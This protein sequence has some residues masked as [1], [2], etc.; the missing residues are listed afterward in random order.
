K[1]EASKTYLEQ[2]KLLVTLAS[3]FLFAPAGLITILK[4]R[5]GAGITSASMQPFI[6]AE[7]LF[8]LSVIAGYVAIGSLA[9]S[10]DMGDF[11]VYRPATR[12]FS[13][14]QFGFYL[15]GLIV[16]VYF[17]VHLMK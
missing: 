7:V 9:G 15:E 13:L 12:F 6:A 11:D 8:V 5:L 2:T 14:A 10:Q 3:A 1:K 16:F 17:G 4:D